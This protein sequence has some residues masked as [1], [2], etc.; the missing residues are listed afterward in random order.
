MKRVQWVWC[1]AAFKLYLALPSARS[2]RSRYGR[3]TLWLLG[4]GGAYAHSA[5][6]GV[7]CKH[8]KF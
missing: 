3:F 6:Y 1:Y 4:Y 5:N 7:F 2:H 8:V